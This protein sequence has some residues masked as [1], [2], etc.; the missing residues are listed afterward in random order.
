ML[1]IVDATLDAYQTQA[2]QNK[3]KENPQPDTSSTCAKKHLIHQMDA[4]Q[5]M[6]KLIIQMAVIVDNLAG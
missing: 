5:A 2:S 6:M 1:D 4:I 3:N